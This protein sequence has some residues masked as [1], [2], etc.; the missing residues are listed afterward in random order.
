[1][2]KLLTSLLLAAALLFGQA[3]NA[4]AVQ[5]LQQVNDAYTTSNTTDTKTISSVTQANT[6]LFFGGLNSTNNSAQHVNYTR[7]TTSSTNVD[8][9]RGD[10]NTTTRTPVYT[11]LQFASGVLKTRQQ[12]LISLN[13][14]TSNTGALSPSVNTAKT[15]LFYAGS[16][17]PST[18]AGSQIHQ[19][20]VEMTSGSVITG[21]SGETDG[22]TTSAVAAL[23]AEFN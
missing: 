12:V 14:T 22:I 16:Y 18:T 2:K 9:V 13:A 20:S 3:A 6:V 17:S 23:A 7:Q 4:A 21:R 15:A 19:F 5:S 10:T 11:V 8:L 1:M